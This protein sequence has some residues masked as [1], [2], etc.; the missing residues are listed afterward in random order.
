MLKWG[1]VDFLLAFASGVMG[2]TDTNPATALL[3][4]LFF[5]GNVVLSVVFTLLGSMNFLPPDS[6]HA[7]GN[8]S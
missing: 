6:D 5:F 2:V 1:L 4:Q 7:H 3:A 8:D